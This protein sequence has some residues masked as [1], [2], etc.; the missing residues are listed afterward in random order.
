MLLV[1]GFKLVTGLNALGLVLV[2]GLALDLMPLSLQ[3][4]WLRLPM[5][6]FLAGLALGAVGLLWSGL[7][8]AAIQEQTRGGQL[9]RLHWVPALL[10]IASHALALLAFAAGCW[11]LLGL[12]SLS[13]MADEAHGGQLEHHSPFIV[14]QSGGADENAMVSYCRH[15][16]ALAR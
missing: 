16:L 1:L 12:T 7:A 6:L 15:T 11:A 8:Q 13:Q 2:F 4:F 5:A 9:R 14:P 10:A 3:A